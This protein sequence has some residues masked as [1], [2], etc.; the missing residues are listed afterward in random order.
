M[1]LTAFFPGLANVYF[2]QWTVMFCAVVLLF[3]LLFTLRDIVQRTDSFLYQAAC[4]LLTG[5]LPIVGFLVYLL[6]RPARTIRQR[7]TDA[8]VREMFARIAPDLEQ[9]LPPSDGPVAEP[10]EPDQ[11]TV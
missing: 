4:V 1:S 10:V 7:E 11:P 8:M 9:P 2:A 5:A 6:I 3:L